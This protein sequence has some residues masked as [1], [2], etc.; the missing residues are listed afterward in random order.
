MP[1]SYDLRQ[2]GWKPFFQQQLTLDEWETATPARVAARDRSVVHLLAE[3][4]AIM[5][6]LRDGMGDLATGDWVLLEEDGRFSRRLDRSSLFSRKAAGTR[7]DTQSIAANVDTAFVVTSMNR[8]FNL[9]R[10]ERYLALAGEAE[11][12]AVL[13]LSKLDQCEEAQRYIDEAQSLDAG[14]PVV[15][16]NG[17]DPESAKGL[18]PWCGSGNTVVFLGSSGV[19]KST[20]VNALFGESVQLTRGIREDDD[21]GRHTTTGR[22]LHLLPG[23]GLLLDTPGMRELQLAACE[24]GID[25][26]FAEI[27]RLSDSC[28]FADCRHQGEPGCAVRAAV[29]AGRI[30]ERRLANY[31]KL[32]REQAFNEAT[33]AEK[34][35][36]DRKLGR[37]YRSVMADKKRY[38]GK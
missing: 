14:L 29:E 38:E 22:T 33:L 13:V 30:D 35:D 4:G 23:G 18:L 21:K 24:R 36:R 34:R 26:T 7:V 32:M 3:A 16:V 25:E 11:V 20:L 5:L 1:D 12:G 31:H 8:D 15:A 19:G 28:R 2:L 9:N 10:I 37:F 17:L 6:E 27:T